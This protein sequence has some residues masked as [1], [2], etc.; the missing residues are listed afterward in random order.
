MLF[1][2]AGGH[3][4]QPWWGL[5]AGGTSVAISG[6]ELSEATAVKFGASN[7]TSFKV[8]SPSSITATAPAGTG[9]VHV[10]VTTAWWHEYDGRG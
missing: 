7:A 8:N 3:R 2:P 4:C 5:E 10:T 1:N 9:T 6:E